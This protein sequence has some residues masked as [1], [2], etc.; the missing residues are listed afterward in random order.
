MSL[1]PSHLSSKAQAANAY[2]AAAAAYSAAADAYLQAARECEA[3]MEDE[4]APLSSAVGYSFPSTSSP[5]PA[6]GC[7]AAQQ[8]AA[9]GDA[10]ARQADSLQ[11]TNAQGV[12]VTLT[13]VADAV[14][15]SVPGFGDFGVL[16]RFDE[17]SGEW[18]SRG[19]PSARGTVPALQIP[20]VSAFVAQAQ[21]ASSLNESS[22]HIHASDCP[23]ASSS[24]EYVTIP[25]LMLNELREAEARLGAASTLDVSMPLHGSVL[26]SHYEGSPARLPPHSMAAHGKELPAANASDKYVSVPRSVL[27]SLVSSLQASLPTERRQEQDQLRP[28]STISYTNVN[29]FAASSSQHCPQLVASTPLKSARVLPTQPVTYVSKVCSPRRRGGVSPTPPMSVDARTS[30]LFKYYRGPTPV[31]ISAPL[32]CSAPSAAVIEPVRTVPAVSP[33]PSDAITQHRQ[34]LPFAYLPSS[35]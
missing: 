3:E 30:P 24:E 32:Q 28:H 1:R 12:A 5:L 29:A 11:F 16:D 10:L 7:K 26:L 23:Q 21:E 33:L 2:K 6:P 9:R 18:I 4:P 8:L 25:R 19:P 31:S 15:I 13:K 35:S 22:V 14:K 20:E 17:A 34:N 27:N